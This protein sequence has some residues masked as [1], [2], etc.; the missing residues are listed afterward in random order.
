M[1]VNFK[2]EGG[3]LM[4]FDLSVKEF[5]ARIIVEYGDKRV[6]LKHFFR[7]PT[8]EDWMNYFRASSQ[9]GLS[10]GR[11]TVELTGENQERDLELWSQ[12]VTRVEGYKLHGADLMTLPN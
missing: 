5:F 2:N 10:K 1:V 8:S 7:F 11:D 4:A 12:L 6:T 3:F 9:V